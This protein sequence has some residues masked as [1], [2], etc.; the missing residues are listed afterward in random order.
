MGKRGNGARAGGQKADRLGGGLYESLNAFQ[1]EFGLG[2]H[3]MNPGLTGEPGQ[4]LLRVGGHHGD[5]RVWG[6]LFDA[7]GGLEPIHARHVEVDKNQVRVRV[8][9]FAESFFAGP[10]D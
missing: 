4:Y 7:A 2:D 8:L 1:A 3:L 10:S 9:E 5:L 6:S